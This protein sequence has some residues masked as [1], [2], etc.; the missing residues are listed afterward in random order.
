M[1][2]ISHDTN[3]HIKQLDKAYRNM[4]DTLHEQAEEI[5]SLR[6]IVEAI[7]HK[8]DGDYYAWMPFEENNLD[9]LSGN[10]LI[11]AEWI[12]Q[13]RDE[14]YRKG[15]MEGYVIIRHEPKEVSK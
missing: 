4:M 15:T 9:T 10:V 1:D 3:Y 11:P 12:R 13:F 8:E 2:Q 5:C 6:A 14:A 7:N